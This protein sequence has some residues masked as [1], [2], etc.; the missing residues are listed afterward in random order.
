M[1][2][3]KKKFIR[4]TTV[5]CV[6][7]DGDVVMAA[8]GQVTM[9]EAVIKHNA[10]K[11]RRLYQDKIMAGFA[12]ST[13]DAFNLFTR[14]EAKL[15]QFHGNLGRAAVELAKDWRT[16]KMLRNLEALLVVADK[17]Q[18]YLIS[19]SGDVIEPDEGIASI[20][21]GGPFAQAAARALLKNTDL[22]ARR[23]VEEAMKIA[24]DICIFTNDHIL[25]E[26]LAA[27]S[28]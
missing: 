16:D 1:R 11:I 23:I 13:A 28:N 27:T 21:S 17:E 3:T 8:D 26:E 20:G 22:P 15:D 19:G 25:V 4:S 24:A 14:F 2:Q 10:R 7:R 18:T 6:R 5:L 9:G 12:G